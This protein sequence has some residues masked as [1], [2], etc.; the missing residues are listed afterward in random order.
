[1]SIVVGYV[2]Q[3]VSH[4][5]HVNGGLFFFLLFF[6]KVIAI[7]I[8]GWLGEAVCHHIGH[9][10]LVQPQVITAFTASSCKYYSLHIISSISNEMNFQY[11]SMYTFY[12]HIS[13]CFSKWINFF[14][15]WLESTRT[16]CLRS[17]YT[18]SG[19]KGILLRNKSVKLNLIVSLCFFK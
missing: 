8:F 9:H 6:T 12:N 10:S 2:V 19:W 18:H 7:I 14:L 15:W 13:G 17:E 16:P 3:H 5:D 1:M 4:W 11:C